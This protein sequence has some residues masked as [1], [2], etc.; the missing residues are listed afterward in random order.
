MCKGRWVVVE[1]VSD[2]WERGVGVN[3]VMVGLIG[4]V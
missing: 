3:E 4:A 2:V 1:C